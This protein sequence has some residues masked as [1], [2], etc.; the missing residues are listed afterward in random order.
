MSKKP[1][2]IK[3]D[4][5]KTREPTPQEEKLD[6]AE[7]LSTKEDVREALLDIFKDVEKGFLQQADRS[8]NIADYW[9]CYNC[10]LGNQQFYNG[11]SKIYVPIV[12]NAV[13]ARKTR[14]VN[15][16]FP[17]NG[18]YVEV[19]TGD[20][21]LPQ[22]EMALLE[23]YVRQ[24]KLRSRV[25]PALAKNS[26]IEGQMTIQIEW[27]E[28]RRHVV[29]KT[30]V[31][32]EI[33]EGIADIEDVDDIEEEEI[34]NGGPHVNV[35]AD[36]DFLVLPFT[37]DSLD[38]ALADGG[39]VTTLC[40][41]SKAKLARKI[42]EKEID[43]EAGDN[44]LEEMKQQEKETERYDKQKDMVDAAGIK[45]DGRGKFALIY[46]TW[47]MLTID[48]E[49]RLC[50]TYYGGKDRV[51]SC[52]RNPYWSDRIDI[53]SAPCDK[54]DGSF[55][56]VSRIKFVAGLQYQAN[57]ACNEGMDSAAYAL[58]P[59]V[60]T[61]PEKNPK[62]GSM[63]LALAAVWETSP[64]DTQFAKFPALWKDAL[65]IVANCKSEIFQSL[66]VNPAQITQAGNPKS[67]KPNQAEIANEQQIDLLTTADV[68][69]I[70]EDEMFSPML[71]FMLELDH[72][73]RDKDLTVREYGETGM[74]TNMQQIPLLSLSKLY[75]FRWFGVENARN[76]QQIQQQIGMLNVLQHVPPQL[77]QGYRFNAGPVMSQMIENS[78]G[79][80]LGPLT[81]VDMRQEL[82]FEP[83]EE[84][85]VLV[86]GFVTPVHPQDDH[87]A[88]I[89]DHMMVAKAT[90]DPS[91]VF[92]VHIMAHLQALQQQ[93]AQTAPG[94]PP[95]PPGGGGSG[96]R[97]G[98]APAAQRPA[99]QPPGAIHT[100]QMKDPQVAPRA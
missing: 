5:G 81:F 34:V 67:K 18:R 13:N 50:L 100:D 44:M 60:M 98:A 24:D 56:G 51:L 70:M 80:R 42:K 41:W 16:L 27:A 61:D 66:S 97:P 25:A 23:H 86:E 38:Q 75:Q 53:I 90:G 85:K 40:R 2:K 8:D 1:S 19:T 95:Q 46:R 9:D 14:F 47:T 58:M 15:Q 11:T 4:P 20:G 78:F 77:Y 37:A 91:G 30:K 89:Q 22:T 36:S 55:K 88:H 10:V 82:S 96:P 84:D 21:T 92:R 79:P 28:K 3:S 26:D 68:V 12:Y 76:A 49:R 39:S 6:R 63:V 72:Q 62:V 59:I 83:A 73:Y 87:M 54:V 74:K 33:E 35:I 31:K 29:Y 57:D 45:G 7:E 32:P 64:N 48:G 71:A 69:T 52:K 99:Q 17:Q 94:G 65:E 93:Q 43:T